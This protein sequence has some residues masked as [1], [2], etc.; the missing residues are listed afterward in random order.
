MESIKR[1]FGLPSYRRFD[2][3][4]S[5]NSRASCANPY[6]EPEPLA[7]CRVG[8]LDRLDRELQITD[9]L[10]TR[11]TDPKKPG[12]SFPCWLLQLLEVMLSWLDY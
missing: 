6:H 9:L 1:F 4:G 10:F 7:A 11:I 3:P 2:Q 8:D 12:I 5:A